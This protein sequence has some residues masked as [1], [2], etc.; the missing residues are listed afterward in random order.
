VLTLSCPI[1]SHD[2]R[3][4]AP[5]ECFGMVSVDVLLPPQCDGNIANVETDLVDEL[6]VVSMHASLRLRSLVAAEHL[7][8]TQ[9]GHP[10]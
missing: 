7:E 6:W 4:L 10:P 1:C 9:D 5:A 3:R 8:L 2:G